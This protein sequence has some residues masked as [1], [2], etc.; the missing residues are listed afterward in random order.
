MGLK[1]EL[2]GRDPAC[3]AG[4]ILV[5]GA[6]RWLHARSVD[7]GGGPSERRWMIDE[8]VSALVK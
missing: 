7:G 5:L 2:Y 6:R 4:G 8:T 1:K 3:G